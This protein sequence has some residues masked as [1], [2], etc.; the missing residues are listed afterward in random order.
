MNEDLLYEIL[1]SVTQV[2]RTVDVS[3]SKDF[4]LDSEANNIHKITKQD[5][6]FDGFTG[7]EDSFEKRKK[8]ATYFKLPP[9]ISANAM[10]D[11]LNK[12]YG[13]EK[14]KEAVRNINDIHEMQ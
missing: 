5:L 2:D 11:L 13:Y 3:N 7:K 4:D 8:L 1:K 14:Y 12:V 6:Y 10:I 9:R